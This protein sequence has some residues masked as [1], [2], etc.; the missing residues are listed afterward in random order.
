MNVPQ[1]FSGFFT[2]FDGTQIYHEI[3]GDDSLMKPLILLHG[4]GGNV[5]A[6]Y[7]QID[8]L[9]HLG[10]TVIVM[11]LRGHGL[12]GRPNNFDSFALEAFAKDIFMLIEHYHVKNIT[13]IAQCL[14]AMAAIQCIHMYQPPLTRLVLIG[15][16]SHMPWYA[17]WI[18]KTHILP[19]LFTLSKKLHLTHYRKGH[20]PVENYRGTSDISLKRLWADI[21]YMSLPCYLTSCAQIW[22]FDAKKLLPT[23]TCPTLIIHG[24]KDSIFPK[25][26]AIRLHKLIKTSKLVILAKA[27]HILLL[28]NAEDIRN[29]L[30]SFL[31]N[32]NYF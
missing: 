31:Q 27:N 26:L 7:P 30:V 32:K 10:Y 25:E 18:D 15:T 20:M 14:G 4:L 21:S 5:T 9:V 11:D 19:V 24:E 16:A 22:Q 23:I 3:Y 29:Q 6:W 8:T 13:I 12:S 17:A 1:Q 28:N 2:S